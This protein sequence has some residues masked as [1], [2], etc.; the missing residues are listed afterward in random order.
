MSNIFRK[1]LDSY[2]QQNDAAPQLTDN[3]IFLFI[4]ITT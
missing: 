1:D 2:A 4:G 3:T